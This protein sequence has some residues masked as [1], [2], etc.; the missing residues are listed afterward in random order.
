MTSNVG[1]DKDSIEST[2][3]PMTETEVSGNIDTTLGKFGLSFHQFKT[4]AKISIRRGSESMIPLPGNSIVL[5]IRRPFVGNTR[6]M[7][8]NTETGRIVQMGEI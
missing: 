2:D 1:R 5:I 3:N 7:A 4:L 6:Y 8:M